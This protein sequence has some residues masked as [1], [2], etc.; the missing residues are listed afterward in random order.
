MPA[1]VIY[2]RKSSE[3]EDRQVLS[4]DSQIQELKTLALRQGIHVGEVLTEA[5][6][7]K[8]PGRP[9]FGELMRRVR[10][11]GV[12][13]VLCWKMD[14]LAR[15]HLDHGQVLQALAD[16]K[17]VSV[18]TSDRTYTPDGNDRFLGNFEL[19]MATKYIDD[20]RA[21]VKRG[22]RARFQRG[23]PNYRPP[24]GYLD[25][26]ATKTIIKD[27]ER[28]QNVRRAWDLLL[29]GAMRPS[30]ILRILNGEWG[31]RS[32]QTRAKGSGGPMSLSGLYGVFE[33]PF[34]KGIIQLTSG[35]TYKGAHDPMVTEAEFARGQEL[36]G[37]PS[38]ARPIQHEFTLSGLIRCASCGRALVAEEHVKPNGKRY[39][40][41]R[42]HRRRSGE[43]CDERTI[44]ESKLSE[45]FA[46]DLLRMRLGPKA[47]AWVRANIRD[48]LEAEI[49]QRRSSHDSLNQAL[50]QA[51]R[52]EDALLT[53][54]L[55]GSI[56]DQTFDRRRMEILDR[57]AHLQLRLARPF[58]SPEDLLERIDAALQFAQRAHEVFLEGTPVQQRQILEAIGSN[59][60]ASGGKALYEAKK[61]FSLFESTTATSLWWAI[62]EDVRTW[63]L[64]GE[65]LW[66]PNLNQSRPG[67]WVAREVG[68]GGYCPAPAT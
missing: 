27:P 3:S 64:S 39:V 26:R 22:N 43:T 50:Q 56:D 37:R 42:C 53:L 67:D 18:I 41:Y 60:R 1:Y 17:L 31:Y 36:L 68:G 28:F 48:S 4:I 59:Y 55:R 24:T 21:N 45:Q 66:I 30:Q 23:W 38:R 11:G 49:S 12:S 34:Y 15:N 10:R 16:R 6:S 8:A 51:V 13:G 65:D 25:N 54:R 46:G 19:G 52:E 63:L 2:A 44:P 47:A 32:R 58:Q 9:V 33:N 62:A 35:E 57:K 7:A 20:L 29:S 14:R 61:P 40:Y 5:R